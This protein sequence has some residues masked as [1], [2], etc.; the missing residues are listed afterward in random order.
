MFEVG[1]II[2]YLSTGSYWLI[3]L[4][5]RDTYNIK[6]LFDGWNNY[7]ASREEFELQIYYKLVTSIFRE[8]E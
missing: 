7:M 5:S 2:C 1:D 8:E 6:P 4:K 3:T